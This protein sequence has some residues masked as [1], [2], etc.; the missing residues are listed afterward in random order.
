MNRFLLSTLLLF[1]FLI[2]FGFARDNQNVCT[3]T[4]VFAEAQVC[5]SLGMFNVDIEFEYDEVGSMGFTIQGNGVIYG[6]FDYGEVF[7]TIG[8]LEG[9][10]STIYEFVVVDV[11]HP[12]CQAY[13]AFDFPV[14]CSPNDCSIQIDDIFQLGCDSL[15]FREIQFSVITNNV[16]PDGFDLFFGAFNIGH[17]DYG[18]PNY[19]MSLPGDGMSYDLIISDTRLPHCMDRFTVEPNICPNAPECGGLDHNSLNVEIGVCTSDSTYT[20]AIIFTYQGAD[21]SLWVYLQG[22]MPQLIST[23]AFPFNL[24]S[25]SSLTPTYEFFIHEQDN[26]Y[27]SYSIEWHSP[28]CSSFN[29][30]SITD[31]FAEIHSCNDSTNLVLVDVSFI[32]HNQ[33]SDSFEIRGNGMLYGTF[34]YGQN[35]YTIGPIEANCDKKYEFVVIDLEDPDCRGEYNMPEAPCCHCSLFDLVVDPGGCTGD[36]EYE[37]YVNFEYNN[38]SNNLF[39]VYSNNVF[40]ASYSY[41]DLPIIISNF[42]ERNGTFDHIKIC[43]HEF[44]DCCVVKEFMGPDCSENECEIFNV[45]AE[46]SECS[47]DGLVYVTIEFDYDNEGIQGFE[48][49]GNGGSYGTFQYGMNSYVIG[50]IEGDCET[51]YEFIVQ[52][53]AKPDCSDFYAF[54][55][56]I[57][58]DEGDCQISNIYVDPIQCTGDGVYSLV[59]N[60]SYENNSS[61]TF[62]VYSGGNLVGTYTYSSLPVLIQNFPEREVEYDIITVCDN[63]NPDCCATLEFMGLDCMEEEEEC[64]IF[65]I[66]HDPIQCT[67]DGTYS[68][69]LDFEYQNPGNEFFEVFSDG[70]L[71]GFYNFNDLPLI[72]EEFPE[73]DAEYDIITICVNDVPDCCE[74]YEFIGLDC[75]E[76]LECAIFEINV[77]PIECTG[78]GTYSLYLNFGYENV[79]NNYFEVFSNGTYI[80]LY[81]F[82]NLP[83][84]I[85]NFP[86]REVEYD[87]ITVCQN[88]NPDCCATLEFMGLDCMEEEET[89][90]IYDIIV[91]PI[92]CTGEGTYSMYLNFEYQNTTNAFFDV[93]SDGVFVGFY[94]Y[95]DLPVF[96]ENFPG[97]DAA[98]DFI[99]ICDNDN[100][101]CCS[102]HEFIGLECHENGD[103]LINEVF[104]EAH[105]CDDHGNFLVD[106]EFNVENPGSGGFV[107]KGNG[108]IY[109]TFD[110]GHNFY[111]I[112]PL[113]GDC[114]TI[115][116]FVVADLFHPDCHG[117][118]VFEEEVCCD[119]QGICNIYDVQGELY[120]CADSS[121]LVLVDIWFSSENVGNQG[122]TI[123]G[124]GIVYDTFE[125]GHNFYTI[126]PIEADCETI[127][128]FIISDLAHPDCSDF[129]FFP[130]PICCEEEVE[131]S[132]GEIDI[133][134]AICTDDGFYVIELDVEYEGTQ[135]LGFDIF[136]DSTFH[137]FHLYET[138][139]VTIEVSKEHFNSPFTIILCE[140]DN[141]GCCNSVLFEFEETD[142]TSQLSDNSFQI[143]VDELSIN[144]LSEI[145]ED[146]TVSL[147]SI[148]GKKH[149]DR[150]F[151][152]SIILST[153]DLT[154]GLYVL[155]IETQEGIYTRKILILN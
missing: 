99:V 69:Y 132:I 149:Y 122:F 102:G 74:S 75:T 19:I 30:C 126:G 42:P 31:V 25:L 72:I 95:S 11:E 58:C 97:R 51:I 140:N 76:E 15:G 77:D 37:L 1:S 115:Y 82:A 123:R 92:E 47:D 17:Y 153:M 13:Y 112:G 22:E 154:S 98:F 55:E 148:D 127:Y 113:N 21:D 43:D 5:D 141:N 2:S 124:N 152:S 28:D 103:C 41:S 136:I 147:Y 88:D 93:F 100:L 56:P 131:C 135:N 18:Q 139:P 35:F 134:E 63:D 155:F 125:Y 36:G 23:K 53:I 80:G 120:E 54:D 38:S 50:P 84:F 105:E 20:A 106:I 83:V 26:I 90:L 133:I 29:D 143:N 117:F 9:D 44:P 60:F 128:E 130:H 16:G 116:E 142:G 81:E 89:C 57:C 40:L 146:Q 6:T 39:D 3:I 108:V 52:D 49:K 144:I 8:P 34:E 85:E 64:A 107:I 27:C 94:A 110:Y 137:S 67:G 65:D 87:I 61:N 104:A 4:N 86:E 59:L 91:E 48:I 121:N 101:S 73:S 45:F 114:E 24:L 96:I 32:V 138:L 7:Y 10:C 151:R 150:S 111:T 70:V 119:D 109:D 68:I 46:H 62:N 78:D 145:K 14:C 66:I 79:T 12:D 33:V 129:F 118:Y 71:I